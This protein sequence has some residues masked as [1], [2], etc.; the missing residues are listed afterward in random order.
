MFCFFLGGGGL[1][2]ER[3]VFCLIDFGF[4]VVVFCGGGRDL[5]CFDLFFFLIILRK[6]KASLIYTVFLW[7]WS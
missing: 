1:C 5:A 7:W 3:V 2:G 4:V 6:M